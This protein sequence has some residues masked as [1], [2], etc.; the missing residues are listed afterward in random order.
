MLSGMPGRP[1]H[2]ARAGRRRLDRRRAGY[3]NV[4]CPQCLRGR[5]S[6]PWP[7]TRS[8]LHDLSAARLQD[9]PGHAGAGRRLE[10]SPRLG[11]SDV[12]RRGLQ[13]LGGDGALR[14][15]QDRKYLESSIRGW[16]AS[17]RWQER[18]RSRTRRANGPDRPLTLR[19]DAAGH[20]RCRTN[21]RRRP[22]RRVPAPQYLGRLRRSPFMRG[23]RRSW[24]EPTIWKSWRRSIAL[25]ATICWRRSTRSNPGGRLPLDSRRAGQDFRQPLGRA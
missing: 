14:L 24:A 9:V 25:A 4:P 2:H 8:G 3:R 1:V 21:E 17:S 22:V 5:A 16:S 15:T 19:T 7:W 10:R 18:Q 6:S 13:G 11:P 12:G 20:G 23:G